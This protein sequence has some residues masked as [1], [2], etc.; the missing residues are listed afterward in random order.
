SLGAFS[1]AGP[2]RRPVWRASPPNIANARGPFTGVVEPRTPASLPSDRSAAG[3]ATG[4]GSTH[5]PRSQT[6][7][8]LQ[9]VSFVQ[10]TCRACVPEHP[11]AV[12]SCATAA[13]AAN[14]TFT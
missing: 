6:R 14:Q 13:V 2:A 12:V 5:T 10:P 9:S 3:L 4:F 8:S 11:A 7:G 1:G